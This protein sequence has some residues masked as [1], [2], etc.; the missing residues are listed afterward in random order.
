MPT[1]I[2]RQSDGSARALEVRAG[3]SLVEAALRFAIPGIEAKC[4][5]NCACVTCHVHIDTVWRPQIGAA[6][7][8]EVSMLDFAEGVEATSRLGCQVRITDDCDGMVVVVPGAQ[9][10]LGL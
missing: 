6:G 5:G 3:M 4:R 7:P 1:I 10:V 8:M 2:Y 9:R